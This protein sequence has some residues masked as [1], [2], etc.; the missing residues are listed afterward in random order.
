MTEVDPLLEARLELETDW[1]TSD[2][3]LLILLIKG[4]TVRVH[5]ILPLTRVEEEV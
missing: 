2:A 4:K 1:K 5:P 3:L